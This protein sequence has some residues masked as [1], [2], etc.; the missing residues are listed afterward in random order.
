MYVA[1][2]GIRKYIHVQKETNYFNVW[3]NVMFRFYKT[4]QKF[5]MCQQFVIDDQLKANLVQMSS[6][7]WKKTEYV[8]KSVYKL[9]ICTSCIINN[10]IRQWS[11]H[12]V[13]L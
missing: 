11:Q 1:P 2:S 6:L 13:D 8:L 7:K 4:Y 3:I 12:T 10:F 5:A 9:N